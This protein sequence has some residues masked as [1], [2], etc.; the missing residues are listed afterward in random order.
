MKDIDYEKAKIDFVFGIAQQSATENYS[1]LSML[2]DR[3]KLVEQ[4]HEQQPLV[5]RQIQ[6]LTKGSREVIPTLMQQE[7]RDV[8]QTK[9]QLQ[10][11]VKE[12]LTLL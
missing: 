6:K 1:F 9:E 4:I 2:V 12:V 10:S 3:L 11:G 7:A 8:K 5:D